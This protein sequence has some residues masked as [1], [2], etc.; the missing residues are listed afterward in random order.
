MQ[1]I[2]VNRCYGGFDL[3]HAAWKLYAAKKNIDLHWYWMSYG[4]KNT[5]HIDEEPTHDNYIIMYQGEPVELD[6]ADTYGIKESDKHLAEYYIDRDDPTLIE[7]IEELGDAASG[8]F[9]NLKVV[10]IPDDV[11]WV[12][13]DYDGMETVEEKHRS[14]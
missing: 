2:A 11:E 3:S 6:P 7:V 13:E 4:V 8:R 12:I 5:A 10:E 14:W 1:K 9:G